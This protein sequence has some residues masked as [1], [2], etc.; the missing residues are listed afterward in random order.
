M[1]KLEV[2]SIFIPGHYHCALSRRDWVQHANESQSNGISDDIQL[3][4]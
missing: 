2:F 1:W 3:V 4:N